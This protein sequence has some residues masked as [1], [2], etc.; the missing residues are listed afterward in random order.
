MTL[1][2]EGG[3]VAGCLGV[4]SSSFGNGDGSWQAWSRTEDSQIGHH[5]H[6]LG[7]FSCLLPLLHVQLYFAATPLG[8]VLQ[9]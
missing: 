5:V 4:A 2:E 7:G 8:M 9:F 6:F 1:V 3:W